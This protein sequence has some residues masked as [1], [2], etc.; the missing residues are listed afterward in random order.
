MV[1]TAAD[2]GSV[3]PRAGS[4]KYPSFFFPDFPPAKRVLSTRSSKAPEFTLKKNLFLKGYESVNF[5]LQRARHEI[6]RPW[7]C[8]RSHIYMQHSNPQIYLLWSYYI[9]IIRPR[10]YRMHAI[11]T[12]AC[13][14]RRRAARRG[15]RACRPASLDS[16]VRYRRTTTGRLEP[17]SHR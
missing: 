10:T 5:R 12:T 17:R 6:R 2:P 3:C 11:A 13:M 14:P 9:Y 1:Y 8:S 4:P 16:L 15:C 7:T